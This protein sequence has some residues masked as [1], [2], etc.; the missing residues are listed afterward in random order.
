[1]S[2]PDVLLRQHAVCSPHV[3]S[4]VLRQAGETEGPQLND[5]REHF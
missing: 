1:M 5:I 3:R 2:R 4:G